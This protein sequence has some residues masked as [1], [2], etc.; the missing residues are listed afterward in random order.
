VLKKVRA[1]PVVRPEPVAGPVFPRAIVLLVLLVCLDLWTSR[2]LGIGLS[3]RP[4]WLG[5][6]TASWL[7][8]ASIL[9]R[10][11]E[12][13]E[14]KSAAKRVR[15]ALRRLLTTPFLIALALVLAVLSMGYSSVEVLGDAEAR[16]AKLGPLE[17]DQDPGWLVL[18]EPGRFVVHSGLSSGGAYRLKVPGYLPTVLTVP[19][20]AGLE[21]LP[22]RDLRRSPTLLLRPLPA[23]LGSLR[24]GGRLEVWAPGEPRPI[25]RSTCGCRTSF[26]L[27]RRQPIPSD[28]LARWSLELRALNAAPEGSSLLSETL[29]EWSRPRH[30]APSRNLLPGTRLDVRVF[31]NAGNLVAQ[32]PFTVT[33]ESFQDVLLLVE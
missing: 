30:L 24:D 19:P 25:A 29:L 27:G 22:E 17:Q 33:E 10:A 5:V 23:T 15:D 11:L 4:A 2:H 20:L 9:D 8:A 6:I 21:I 16:G 32:T 26:L 12:D 18:G 28:A 1:A 7:A 3:R 14:K 31:S 13:E